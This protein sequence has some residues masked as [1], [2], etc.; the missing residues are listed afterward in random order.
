[1]IATEKML[2]AILP[3]NEPEKPAPRSVRK[4]RAPAAARKGR[5]S[6]GGRG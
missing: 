2:N 1:V 4:R 3:R 6:R 5:S